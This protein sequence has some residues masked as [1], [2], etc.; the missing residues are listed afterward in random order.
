MSTEPRISRGVTLSVAVSLSVMLLVAC[1]FG[2]YY[3]EYQALF[4]VMLSGHL[5]PGFL[6]ESW[7]YQGY[8]GLSYLYARLYA[9]IPQIE[10]LS[11]ITYAFIAVS[12]VVFLYLLWSLLKD[13]VSAPVIFTFQVVCGF[14][15]LSDHVLNLVNARMVFLMCGASMLGMI[16]LFSEKGTILKH[17]WIYAGLLLLFLMGALSRSEPALAVSLLLTCFSVVYN[18]NLLRGVLVALPPFFISVAVVSSILLDIRNS[19]QFHKRVEPDIEMQFTMRKNVVPLSTMTNAR[20]SLRY[21]AAMRMVW[22]DPKVISVEF[23]RGLIANPSYS[24]W[25]MLQWERTRTLLLDFLRL[26]WHLSIFS[27]LL[28]L[29]MVLN[30]LARGQHIRAFLL[31]LYGL[32]FVVAVIVQTYF[33]KMTPW[34]FSPYITVFSASLVLLFCKEHLSGSPGILVWAGLLILLF[35]TATQISFI[36]S[37]ATQL[38]HQ[39]Q[40]RVQMCD[41]SLEMTQGGILLLTPS[42]FQHFLSST[43]PLHPFNYSSFNKLYIYESQILSLLPGYKDYLDSECSC[44]VSH[45]PDFYRFLLSNEAYGPVY[46]LTTTDRADLITRYLLGIHGYLLYHCPMSDSTMTIE[47]RDGQKDELQ[48]YRLQTSPCDA[49]M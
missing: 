11:W 25:D 16:V 18:G 2:S 45:F 26:Y 21:E 3:E 44:D 7:Y 49:E 48:L 30:R 22:G 28:L 15:F 13:R 40:K 27:A 10:W 4:N 5:S 20:D 32:G 35:A 37:S 6:F 29:L 24:S 33:V 9:L 42:S 23:M 38:H 1:F 46:S 31:T 39:M 8:I 41:R 17:P 14:L 12:G 19:E 36:F 47:K 34:S 43:P